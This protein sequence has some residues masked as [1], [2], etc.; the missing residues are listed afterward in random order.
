[1]IINIYHR[2]FLLLKTKD[3]EIAWVKAREYG[4]WFSSIEVRSEKY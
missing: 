2:G 4:N 1:M 3:P